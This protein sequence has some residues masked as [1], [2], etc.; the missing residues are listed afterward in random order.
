M[1]LAEITGVVFLA[2]FSVLW[3]VWL[4]SVFAFLGVWVGEAG[5]ALVALLFPFAFA[6][7]FGKSQEGLEL[8]SGNAVL[9]LWLAGRE[10]QHLWASASNSPSDHKLPSASESDMPWMDSILTKSRS[11]PAAAGAFPSA[12]PA[13]A[14][15]FPS[16]FPAGDGGGGGAFPSAFPSASPSLASCGGRGLIGAGESGLMGSSVDG[17]AT[18]APSGKGGLGGAAPLLLASLG[19][20]LLFLDDTGLE[21]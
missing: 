15:A 21:F 4:V 12:S 2:S 3:G 7:G 6:A 10:P 17:S 1:H 8:G 20:W 19:S 11:N 13:A 18:M 9:R 14:G 5:V 16:A